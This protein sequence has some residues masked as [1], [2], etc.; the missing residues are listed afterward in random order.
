MFSLNQRFQSVT[1]TALTYC[2]LLIALVIA[3]T[4]LQLSVHNK[5]YDSIPLS[6][7][8]INNIQTNIRS[9]RMFGGSNKQNMKLKFDLSTDL[10]SLWTWNTKQVF[11]YLTGEYQDST[12]S[13]IGKSTGKVTFW[14]KIITQK[15]DAVLDM[16]NIVSKYSV[17]DKNS[18]LKDKIINV[19]LQWN[20]QPYVGP[21]NFGEIVVP[22][23][24]LPNTVFTVPDVK[25]KSVKA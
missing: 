3:L 16:E 14:D 9:S 7:F 10:S 20:I 6:N 23:E 1:N 12:G 8:H 22:K 4:Q 24:L 2:V 5:V 11:V 19:K 18:Q 13:K 15:E 21:L 17:W 25:R